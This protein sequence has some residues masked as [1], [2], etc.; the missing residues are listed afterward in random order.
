MI[1]IKKTLTDF[2]IVHMQTFPKIKFR[3]SGE[4][5]HKCLNF[6]CLKLMWEKQPV[7]VGPREM[8]PLNESGM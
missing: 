7:E 4:K 6:L 5:Y 1:S 3:F 8:V 2:I